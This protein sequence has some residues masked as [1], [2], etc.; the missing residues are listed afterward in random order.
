MVG[1]K[2]IVASIAEQVVGRA[3]ELGVLDRALDGLERGSPAIVE[4][5]GEPGIGKTRLLAELS[6]RANASGKLVLSG[7]AAEFERDLPFWVFVDAL[8]EYVEGLEPGRLDALSD[9]VRAELAQVLPVARTPGRRERNSASRRA[10]SHAPRAARAAGGARP[11]PASRADA[12]RPPLGRLGLD[13]AGRGA[14]APPAGRRRADRDLAAPAPGVR[15]ARGRVGA[16]GPRRVADP[17]R[18]G[19]A[20]RGRR[21]RVPRRRRSAARSPT[22]STRRAAATPSISSSSPARAT[23]A[24]AAALRHGRRPTRGSRGAERGDRRPRGG[25]RPAVGRCAP[26]PRGGGGRG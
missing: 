3:A 16:G 12:R 22:R 20:E 26:G 23:A 9:D 5:V 13:R 17:A 6:A 8:D 21:P 2:D 25:A 4:L 11:H 24:Q 15:A 1:E 7:R 18:A 14:A 19:L 10:L